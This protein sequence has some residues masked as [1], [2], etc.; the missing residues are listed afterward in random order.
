MR[1]RLVALAAPVALVGPALL[2]AACGDHGG[3]GSVL[4]SGHPVVLV[5]A[6]IDGAT[7]YTLDWNEPSIVA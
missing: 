6:E 5:D 1:L 4:R 7:V 3:E 2:L